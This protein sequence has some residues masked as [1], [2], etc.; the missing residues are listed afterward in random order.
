MGESARRK[1]LALHDG[2]LNELTG[3]IA[4]AVDEFMDLIRAWSAVNNLVVIERSP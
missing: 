2:S 1:Y 4:D 3:R